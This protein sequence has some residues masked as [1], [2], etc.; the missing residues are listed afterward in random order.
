MFTTQVA[1]MIIATKSCIVN[2]RWIFV[3]VINYFVIRYNQF[4]YLHDESDIQIITKHFLYMY[5]FFYFPMEHSFAVFVDELTPS[6]V[7]FI[8]LLHYSGRGHLHISCW[9]SLF[10]CGYIHFVVLVGFQN[11]LSTRT[12]TGREHYSES[13]FRIR[14]LYLKT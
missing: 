5:I 6:Q 14:S 7:Y 3:N 4:N 12:L 11:I 10:I 8:Y 1:V 2:Y 9:T 13:Y